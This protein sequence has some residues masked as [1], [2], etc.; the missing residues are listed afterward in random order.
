[1]PLRQRDE[2]D[3]REEHKGCRHHNLSYS[4][5]EYHK[6]Q[7]E[8]HKDRDCDKSWDHIQLRASKGW[9][10]GWDAHEPCV[11]WDLVLHHA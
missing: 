9:V 4:T 6:H 10:Q 11:G 3:K 2:L 8:R 5:K 1:M 7:P